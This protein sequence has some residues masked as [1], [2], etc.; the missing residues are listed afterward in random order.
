MFVQS[1]MSPSVY[2]LIEVYLIDDILVK[3]ED[4]F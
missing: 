4:L 3:F 1:E 2:F